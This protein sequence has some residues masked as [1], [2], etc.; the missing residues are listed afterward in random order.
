MLSCL[1]ISFSKL[2]NFIPPLLLDQTG[3]P[4]RL[5][6]E[7]F[8]R[9]VYSDSHEAYVG[10]L[11]D[12]SPMLDQIRQMSDVVVV[13]YTLSPMDLV[14]VSGPNEISLNPLFALFG[15]AYMYEEGKSITILSESGLNAE[16][17]A[18]LTSL[19][20][21]R[22]L[23]GPTADDI[24]EK[25][26][27]FFLGIIA[28][29]SG[30]GRWDYYKGNVLK[31]RISRASFIINK[32]FRLLKDHVE[33][34]NDVLFVAIS[35]RYIKE[36]L[37]NEANYLQDLLKVICSDCWTVE[38][39][40]RRLVGSDFGYMLDS[41]FKAEIANIIEGWLEKRRSSGEHLSII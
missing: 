39:V 5:R 4:K 41:E 14:V 27:F 2:P 31:S 12:L 1:T 37:A 22:S 30:T 40:R 17:T 26:V 11:Q 20:D 35:T 34:G 18:Y 28:E 36:L 33:I 6:V 13:D 32:Y 23:L 19:I 38:D 16:S 7:S 9:L 29:G 8:L 10:R 3:L 24:Y 25:L 21:T 15:D